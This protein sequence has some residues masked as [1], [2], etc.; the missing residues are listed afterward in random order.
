MKVLFLSV[1]DLGDSRY[2]RDG[3]RNLLDTKFGS[4]DTLAFCGK[5]E[6]AKRTR[7]G[8]R[9]EIDDGNRLGVIVGTFNKDVRKD[10]EMIVEKF[11][12]EK[13]IYLLIYGNPYETEQL[14]INVNQ[15]NG[16]IRVDKETCG[17]FH[18]L[19]EEACKYLLGKTENLDQERGIRSANS[20]EYSSEELG[21]TKEEE[22]PTKPESEI[23]PEISNDDI[24]AFI[25]SR[26]KGK[27]VRTESVLEHF[28]RVEGLEGKIL[29]LM[30]MGELYE[31][32]PGL[33]R[34]L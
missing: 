14:Y 21:T 8:P 10:A 30:E 11:K 23:Q 32:K 31:P 15:D 13:D 16:V 17:R 24:V 27:G 9:L 6:S 1:K 29:E 5:L 25:K 4:A 12:G 33:L 18:E 19:R 34:V 22:P 20:E 26:D 7:Y 28:K 2:R 3:K